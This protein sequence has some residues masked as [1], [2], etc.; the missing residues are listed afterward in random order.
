MTDKMRSYVKGLMLGICG[1]PLPFSTKKEPVAYLYNG[2][3]LPKLPEWD[4]EKYPYAVLT[5]S[6]SSIVPYKISFY[7]DLFVIHDGNYGAD[8][9]SLLVNG[10]DCLTST[11]KSSETEWPALTTKPLTGNNT[12]DNYGVEVPYKRRLCNYDSDYIFWSNHSFPG[13]NGE[14]WITESEPVPVYE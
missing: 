13:P 3:R 10:D 7:R 12:A 6:G 5:G 4:R 1:K 8:N 11:I 14:E 2:V 9:W